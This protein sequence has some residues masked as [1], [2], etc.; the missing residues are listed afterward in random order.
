MAI[1]ALVKQCPVVVGY[2][3]QEFRHWAD[4]YFF[5]IKIELSDGSMLFAREYVDPFERNYSFH[6]QDNSAQL[7]TRWDNAPHHSHL[8]TYP[9]HKHLAGAGV[10]KPGDDVGRCVVND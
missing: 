9:H 2:D 3:V 1:L 10:G 7:I 6:W 4:G 8:N 5:R